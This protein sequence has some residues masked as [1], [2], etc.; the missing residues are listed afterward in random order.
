VEPGK[1]GQAHSA[2]CA[3]GI[4]LGHVRRNRHVVKKQHA[5]LLAARQAKPADFAGYGGIKFSDVPNLPIIG[6]RRTLPTGRVE[7]QCRRPTG[8]SL[9]PSVQVLSASSGIAGSRQ[10]PTALHVVVYVAWN[11]RNLVPERRFSTAEGGRRT[12]HCLV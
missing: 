4:L 5:A 6:V 11:E 8:E 10:N 9:S 2:R 1:V 7:Q 3:C 12:Y